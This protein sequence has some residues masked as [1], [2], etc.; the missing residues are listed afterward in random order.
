MTI[1]P[2]A[3]Q[4]PNTDTT[5]NEDVESSI[6]FNTSC[7]HKLRWKVKT[8]PNFTAWRNLKIRLNFIRTYYNRSYGML[9]V[10]KCVDVW[11]V[12]KKQKVFNA[13]VLKVSFLEFVSR[14]SFQRYFHRSICSRQWLFVCLIVALAIILPISR[15]TILLFRNIWIPGGPHVIRYC[16]ISLRVLKA[17]ILMTIEWETHNNHAVI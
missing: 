3:Y 1:H 5:W 4:I 11:K 13:M 2:Y 17:R 16:Y 7:V 6:S 12:A 8:F 10:A 15:L 14:F 9:L